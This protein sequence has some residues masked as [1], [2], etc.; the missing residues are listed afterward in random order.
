MG[1]PETHFAPPRIPQSRVRSAHWTSPEPRQCDESRFG[2]TPPT[3]TPRAPPEPGV[4]ARLQQW[5]PVRTR[6]RLRLRPRCDRYAGREAC[7]AAHLGLR[8][9]LHKARADL[10]IPP[11]PTPTLE[12]SPP[13]CRH[14]A[15]IAAGLKRCHQPEV[16]RPT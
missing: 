4:A 13:H 3:S 12:G 14:V 1:A 10:A 8:G 16:R 9:E 7:A 5:L 15:P 2:C 11:L 6:R